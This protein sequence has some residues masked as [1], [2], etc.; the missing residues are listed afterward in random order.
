MGGQRKVHGA[1]M[2]KEFGFNSSL[3]AFEGLGERI[4]LTF[5]AR[6]WDGSSRFPLSVQQAKLGRG[7]VKWVKRYNEPRIFVERALEEIELAR[8]A[9][10]PFYI[11]LWTDA[12]HTPLEAPPALRGNGSLRAQYYG[13]IR[14]LD[15]QL[16]RIFSY[17]RGN[18]ELSG[19][20]LVVLSSDNGPSPR[21]GSSGG[22]RGVKGNLYEG[23]V[24]EP[25]I[26]WAP[27]MIKDENT[28]K[29]NTNTVLAGMDMPVSLLAIAGIQAHDD[30]E[31]D[32]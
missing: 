28:G 12:V 10:K 2:I 22:L 30:V 17:I 6:E 26:V 31:V 32:G 29:V 23:G 7:E 11:N 15:E 19:N 25:F 9:E 1:P 13:V 16:G 20:T 18:P 8:Q 27:G 3:T 5:E 14:E 4:G 24:R 21:I